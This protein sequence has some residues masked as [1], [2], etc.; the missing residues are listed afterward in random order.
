[1]HLKTLVTLNGI[2]AIAFGAAA[3]NADVVN[4][5][6]NG[7]FEQSPFELGWKLFDQIPGWTPSNGV[8]IELQ[9]NFSGWQAQ[10]GTYYAELDSH[11]P[12]DGPL[13]IYQDIATV[14]GQAYDLELWFSPRPGVASN[15]LEVHWN[16]QIL[17]TT[18]ASGTGLN[19]TE[20]QQL[21]Y[22]VTAT[23]DTSRL[24]FRLG[25]TRNNLGTFIDNVSVNVAV[26]A[27]GVVAMMGVVGP[28][29][30]RRRRR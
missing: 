12:G 26:P 8:Q 1:M 23:A 10:D 3:A 5:V 16:G 2:A 20:W 27:P 15:I 29:A 24:E 4:H 11:G 9:R 18:N 13:G 6:T 28:L 7:S 22:S 14:E 30:A 17:G 19:N 25:D 21:T